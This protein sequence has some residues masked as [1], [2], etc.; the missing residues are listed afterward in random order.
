MTQAFRMTTGGRI[1]RSRVLNFRFDGQAMTGHPGDTLASALLANGRHFIARSLK[2]HRPR[3]ILSAGLEEPSA[4]VTVDCGQGRVPNLKATE[5]VLSDG[6]EVMSQ[7][8]WPNLAR[9][10]GAFLGLAGRMLGAGFYY[11]TFMWPKD[12]WQRRYEAHLRRMAGHGRVD[13]T[14]DPGLYDKRRIFCD[15]LVIGGG[16]AGLSAALTA[17]R[18]GATVVIAEVAPDFG[19]SALWDG[20]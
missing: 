4:L 9:D 19:G 5:V 18:G 2:Y 14:A 11:K 8:H 17:A 15:I 16:P 6:M 1:D 13:P 10:A 20:G 3:G 7:N 12:G